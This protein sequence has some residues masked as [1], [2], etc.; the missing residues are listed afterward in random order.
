MIEVHVLSNEEAYHEM[1]L[2]NRFRG[3]AVVTIM[4]RVKAESF[5]EEIRSACIAVGDSDSLI[6]IVSQPDE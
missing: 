3:D 1:L 2:D 4:Q 6:A 5:I